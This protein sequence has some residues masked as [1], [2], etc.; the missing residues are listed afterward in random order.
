[1]AG[2]ADMTASDLGWRGDP[3]DL[4]AASE[5]DRRGLVNRIAALAPA[6]HRHAACAGQPVAVFFAERGRS[7][8]EALTICARCD[9]RRACLAEALADPSLDFGV[10]GG[11]TAQARRAMRR[12]R[13][14]SSEAT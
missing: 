7:N 2:M 14:P 10:R 1:M 9:V 3:S 11:A 12:A 4:V 8:S 13:R 5:P 6:W